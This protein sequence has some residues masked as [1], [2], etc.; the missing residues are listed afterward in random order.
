MNHHTQAT[1]HISNVTNRS[2]NHYADNAML[3]YQTR[4]A[5]RQRVSYDASE[6]D[7]APSTVYD[8]GK[9]GGATYRNFPL[10][11]ISSPHRPPPP[12]SKQ[13]RYSKHAN[14]YHSSGTTHKH[15]SPPPPSNT[16]HPYN[17]MNIYPSNHEQPIEEDL[18]T[19]Q[20]RAPPLHPKYPPFSPRRLPADQPP[21]RSSHHP[22]SHEYDA[23]RFQTGFVR[24]MDSDLDTVYQAQK[25]AHNL[26][27]L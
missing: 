23:S 5:E 24:N 19:T 17:G 20:P 1:P 18:P 21:P 16:P 2:S 25:A 8:D 13:P 15:H 12:S 9:T 27:H 4:I 11:T 7:Q 26:T 10:S 22:P 6:S 14:A 3:P